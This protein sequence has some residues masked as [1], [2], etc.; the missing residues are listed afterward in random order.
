MLDIIW[1]YGMLCSKIYFYNYNKNIMWEEGEDKRYYGILWSLYCYKYH[2]WSM[3]VCVLILL[4]T[5][6]VQPKIIGCFK[7]HN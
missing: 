2:S 7:K 3:L 4:L 6:I 1:Y 5:A